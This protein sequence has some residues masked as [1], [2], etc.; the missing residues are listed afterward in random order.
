[1]I[2]FLCYEETETKIKEK[3]E[4]TVRKIEREINELQ[5]GFFNKKKEKRRIN[6]VD[7]GLSSIRVRFWSFRIAKLIV[8]ILKEGLPGLITQTQ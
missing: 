4:K 7:T 1:M 6:R 3:I 2:D 5:G 8:R